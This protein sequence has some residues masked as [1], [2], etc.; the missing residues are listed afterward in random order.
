[1]WFL[2]EIRVTPRKWRSKMAANNARIQRDRKMLVS[3]PKMGLKPILKEAKVTKKSYGTDLYSYLRAK[4][5]CWC[6][7]YTLGKGTCTGSLGTAA[8]A[9]LSCLETERVAVT[10]PWALTA[11][12]KKEA[13]SAPAT[14]GNFFDKM[15]CH[16]W[17]IIY[18]SWIFFW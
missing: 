6:I 12:T 1:M 17:R 16:Q 5:G 2:K 13:V 9:E 4:A 8:G 11:Q 15:N 18:H 10:K 3:H 7:C 14:F